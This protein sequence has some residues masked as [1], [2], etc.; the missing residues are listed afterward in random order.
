MKNCDGVNVAIFT[1]FNN[2]FSQ[3]DDEIISISM[4]NDRRKKTI[5]IIMLKKM[6]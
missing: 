5:T 4:Q 6:K 3:K 2:V 1:F